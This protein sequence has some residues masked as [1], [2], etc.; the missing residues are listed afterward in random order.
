[1]NCLGRLLVCRCRLKCVDFNRA[2]S[3]FIQE[4]ST[5]ERTADHGGTG[6]NEGCLYHSKKCGV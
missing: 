5:R 6:K 2:R 1:M 3:G 4:E